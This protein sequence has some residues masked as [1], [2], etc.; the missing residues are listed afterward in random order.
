MWTIFLVIIACMGIGLVGFILGQIFLQKKIERK[1]GTAFRNYTQ[2]QLLR[3][4]DDWKCVW[5][6][7]RDQERDAF[8][9]K[10]AGNDPETAK[11]D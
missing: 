5:D 10:G 6:D 1:T 11:E 3:A 4:I 8:I 7:H 9:Y 2:A